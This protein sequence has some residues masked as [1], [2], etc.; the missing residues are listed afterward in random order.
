MTYAVIEFMPGKEA[1]A[2]IQGPITMTGRLV[3]YALDLSPAG[4]KYPR[5]IIAL[6]DDVNQKMYHIFTGKA[7]ERLFNSLNPVIGADD[8]AV[9]WV[10]FDKDYGDK[11]RHDWRLNKITIQK[12]V[13]APVAKSKPVTNRISKQAKQKL[14]AVTNAVDARHIKFVE[15]EDFNHPGRVRLM[16]FKNELTV[17][18]VTTLHDSFRAAEQTYKLLFSTL[19]DS[20]IKVTSNY[21]EFKQQISSSR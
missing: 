19:V 13:S 4:A 7:L 1:E 2:G 18:S 17:P 5:Y 15:T 21:E 8:L 6:Q 3:S 16:H 20:N 9:T 10:G 11:G 12:P 14:A